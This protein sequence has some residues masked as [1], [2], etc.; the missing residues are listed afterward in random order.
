MI[1]TCCK[2]TNFI[3]TGNGNCIFQVP[4]SNFFNFF[5]E[6]FNIFYFLLKFTG[7]NCQ[8]YQYTYNC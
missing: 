8:A 6:I 1:N 7:K 2:S 3:L 4:H 5:F